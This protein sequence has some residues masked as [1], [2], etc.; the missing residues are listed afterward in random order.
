MPATHGSPE[1]KESLLREDRRLLG[2][3]LG[4]VIR[5]QAGD[6]A[7]ERIERIRQ[8]AVRFHREDG[9][10]GG[11]RAELERELNA[12]DLNETLQLV[13]AFSYFSH[14]LNIAE[15]EQQH[16]RRRAHAEAG[17]PRRPGSFS[18]AL[19]RARDAGVDAPALLQ[20]FE[21]ARVAP[22]LTA[23]PTEVQRQSILDCEREIA[24]L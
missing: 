23:H 9:P 11:G 2:R 22:V 20:W 18:Y 16:R 12:L 19:D 14:L 24:R 7:L 10:H 15:D 13:R 21:R 3:L 6:A 5:S 8:T 1:E 17:S 4:E